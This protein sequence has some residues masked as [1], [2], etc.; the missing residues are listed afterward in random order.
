MKLFQRIRSTG[1]QL[2]TLF[3]CSIALAGLSNLV[4]AS[5][6][7]IKLNTLGY[8][9]SCG[10]EVT[11]K[12]SLIYVVW[13]MES[14]RQGRLTFDL[15]PKHPLIHRAEVSAKPTADF[16]QIG[17]ALHPVLQ[18]RVGTRDLEKRA[19]WTIFIDRMQN[20]PSELFHANLDRKRASVTSQ[21]R[22]VTLTIGGLSAGPFQGNLR[23]TF[24]AG[25]SFV[26][27]EAVMK[28]PRKS[29]AFLYDFGLVCQGTQPIKLAWQDPFGQF[30]S[31]KSDQIQAPKHLA[32]GGRAIT[33]GFA[34]GSIGAFPP[35]HRYF[36]PLDFSDNLGNIWLG[37]NYNQQPSAFGF[38]IRHDPTGDN[39]YVPWFNAPPHTEQEMGLFLLFSAGST[40][41]VL[42]EIGRL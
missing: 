8:K 25:N 6:P 22:R 28:T 9:P 36:Y 20:K 35:P 26:L 18:V 24:Y 15:D 16:Q 23:W 34:G 12:E 31:Q 41:S 4:A 30:K 29:T 19:G 42:E 10:I 21:A 40:D 2:K 3:A 37:P 33:A 27:Q 13:P 32:V 5:E 1:F 39:R 38:G 14:G 11:Q 7:Q 17:E